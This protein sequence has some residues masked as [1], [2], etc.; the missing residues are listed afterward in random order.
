M[1]KLYVYISIVLS[2]IITGTRAQVIYDGT[3]SALINGE[4]WYTFGNKLFQKTD[5]P[6]NISKSNTTSDQDEYIGVGNARYDEEGQE[7]SFDLYGKPNESKVDIT[8]SGSVNYPSNLEIRLKKLD[9]EEFTY[10]IVKNN[11]FNYNS[12]K[13]SVSLSSFRSLTD[14]EVPSLED[15][16]K[17]SNLTVVLGFYYADHSVSFS[18]TNVTFSSTTVPCTNATAPAITTQSNSIC[19]GSS[20]TLS[21]SNGTLNDAENWKWY[22]GSCGSTL[23]GTGPAIT[24]APEATTRYYVRGEGGCTTPG[25][26]GNIEITVTPANLPEVSIS[27]TDTSACQSSYIFY[28]HVKDTE[29]NTSYQW[30]KNGLNIGTNSNTLIINALKE[31]DEI[32]VVTTSNAKCASTQA[33]SSEKLIISECVLGIAEEGSLNPYG[34][35]NIEAGENALKIYHNIQE[36][37]GELV[38]SDATGKTLYKSKVDNIRSSEIIVPFK[39]SHSGM[40]ILTLITDKNAYVRKSILN[41]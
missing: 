24:V 9:G 33:V 23:L 37:S 39:N 3:D 28:A 29:S 40:I 26:C 6:L 30:K 20:A 31:N 34:L 25:P 2:F 10:F 22:S 41:R 14:Q 8:F 19:K 15:I 18:L 17:F 38:I 12:K 35:Y 16:G 7:E 11:T 5:H 1:K 27:A 4:E 21:I 36:N 32:Y 13:I